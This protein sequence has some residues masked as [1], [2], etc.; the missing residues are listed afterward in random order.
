MSTTTT[1]ASIWLDFVW[2]DFW[3]TAKISIIE[4]KRQLRHRKLG[5]CIVFEI[6]KNSSSLMQITNNPLGLFHSVRQFSYKTQHF[7]ECSN[8]RYI[9]FCFFFW[10][11][12]S[13]SE[14]LHASSWLIEMSCCG[15]LW[16]YIYVCNID[17]FKT[18][19]NRFMLRNLNVWSINSVFILNELIRRIVQ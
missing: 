2:V 10:F 8:C 6:N 15:A 16:V 3:V 18:H 7:G 17:L 13:I 14:N 9:I 5:S 1:C 11:V 19:R 4:S 12:S